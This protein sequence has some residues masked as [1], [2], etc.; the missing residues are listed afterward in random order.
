[1]SPAAALVSMALGAIVLIGWATGAA[2]VIA[3]WPASSDDET[4]ERLAALRT[5]GLA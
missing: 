2:E 4:L 5:E 3:D 1:M